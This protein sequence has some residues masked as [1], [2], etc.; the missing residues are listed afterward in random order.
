MSSIAC[1]SLPFQ[2]IAAYPKRIAD[3]AALTGLSKY[4]RSI[5][6]Y[7]GG[8][9]SAAR[10][11]EGKAVA[12]AS[13]PSPVTKRRRVCCI[14]RPPCLRSAPRPKTRVWNGETPELAALSP[15]ILL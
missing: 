7:S 8:S 12:A 13:E 1:R 10:L 6:G 4:E 5:G 11:R 14:N 3:G 15:L 2:V 9:N